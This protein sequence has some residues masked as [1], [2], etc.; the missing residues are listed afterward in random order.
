MHLS[1]T[2]NIAF[3]MWH[4]IPV[5]FP[6]IGLV[7]FVVMPNHINGIIAAAFAW[8]IGCGI[9]WSGKQVLHFSEQLLK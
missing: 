3:Q 7:A 1:E 5:H 9:P 6:F 8:S 2:G 4:E